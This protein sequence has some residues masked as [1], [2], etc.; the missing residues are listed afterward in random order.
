MK[1]IICIILFSF[2]TLTNFAQDW[3]LFPGKDTTKVEL[4]LTP[5]KSIEKGE[6][7]GKIVIKKDNRI[8]GLNEELGKP[9]DGISVK[10]QGYRLQVVASSRKSSVD[11]E[12][13]KAVSYNNK[14]RTYVDYR[15]PNFRL[16]L[17]DF[18]T[19]LEAQKLQFELKDLFPSAIV[20]NDLIN[21][22][23]IE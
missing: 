13:A 2:L 21:L 17:G 5:V 3:K 11:A 9:A 4:D 12:R 15:Q 14:L 18:K 8:D 7:E 16:R 23:E 1:A 19:K 10:I 20:V 6:K 22:P